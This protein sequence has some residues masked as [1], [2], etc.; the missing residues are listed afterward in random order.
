[1]MQTVPVNEVDTL[2][3]KGAPPPTKKKS[4]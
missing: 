3:A 2:S 1:M 4:S